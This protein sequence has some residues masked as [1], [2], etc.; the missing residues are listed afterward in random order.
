MEKSVLLRSLPF[1]AE[2]AVFKVKSNFPK[3]RPPDTQNAIKIVPAVFPV[4]GDKRN[5]RTN[6]LLAQ[7]HF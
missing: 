2:S 5:L 7:I 1:P 4:I 3:L 6:F